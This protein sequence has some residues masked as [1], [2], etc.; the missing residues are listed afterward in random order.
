MD[1]G[2]GDLDTDSA[3]APLHLNPRLNLPVRAMYLP[4]IAAQAPQFAPQSHPWTALY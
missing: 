3:S 2:G 1:A 4:Q